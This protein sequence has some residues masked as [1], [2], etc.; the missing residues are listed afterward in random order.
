MKRVLLLAAALLFLASPFF[1]SARGT[2]EA[3][4]TLPQ[5]GSIT[6]ATTTSTQDSGLL[7][8]LLPIFTAETEWI[9]DVIAVGTG[10]A[11]RMGRDG[12]ADVLLVHARAEE[13]QFMEE[14]YGSVRYDVMYNDFLIVGPRGGSIVHNSN[15]LQTFRELASRDLPFVSRGDNSGTHIKERALWNAAGVNARNMSKYYSVGQGMGAALQIAHEM[16]AYTLTDRATW[17]V[18]T[19]NG[20]IDLPAVSEHSEELKNYYGVMLVNPL[21]HPHTNAEGGRAFVEWLVSPA[22][23][24]LISQY[25]FQEFGA[26]LFTPNADAR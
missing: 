25:G 3:S 4:R 12:D 6:L 18:L 20:A 13:L 24:K 8:F 10:A 15:V 26:S 17:L 22:A 2:R 7:N 9:V 16:L 1:L 23:H 11:L 14:G 19:R 21:R 5:K